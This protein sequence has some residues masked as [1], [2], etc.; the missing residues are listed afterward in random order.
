MRDLTRRRRVVLNLPE[1]L[2]VALEHFIA[3]A[4]AEIDA[5]H[6]IGIRLA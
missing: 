3:A 4:N 6:L 2:V 5:A 1:F